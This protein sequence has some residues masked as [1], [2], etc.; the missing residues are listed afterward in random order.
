MLATLLAAVPVLGPTT[1]KM[2]VGKEAKIE[3]Y[4]I[5][6]VKTNQHFGYGGEETQESFDE[7]THDSESVL[8]FYSSLAISSN[9]QHIPCRHALA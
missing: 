2:K 6:S 3:D 9:S 5:Y 1:L 7:G 8:D 4:P